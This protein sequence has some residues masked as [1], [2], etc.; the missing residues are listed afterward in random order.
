LVKASSIVSDYPN[1][2]KGLGDSFRQVP[3]LEITDLLD[4]VL[5]VQ[6][7]SCFIPFLVE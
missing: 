2:I 7:L 1:N 4:G 5:A 6:Y 3:A